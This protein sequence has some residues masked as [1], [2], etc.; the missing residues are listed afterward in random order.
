MYKIGK[1]PLKLQVHV[2]RAVE[3]TGAGAAGAVF[4]ERLDA[5]F[6][7]RRLG[8]Q[9]EV[10]VRAQHDAAFALH[11]DLDVLAGLERVEVGIDALV[12]V[13]VSQ[14]EFFAFFK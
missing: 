9:T 10:V 14:R 12:A 2:Q 6:N 8:S 5:G 7:D 13:F 1:L 4:F 3:E 11:D